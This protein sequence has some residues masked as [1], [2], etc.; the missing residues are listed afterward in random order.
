MLR[1]NAKVTFKESIN[2]DIMFERGQGSPKALRTGE[3]LTLQILLGAMQRWILNWPLN[4]TE[5]PS[6]WFTS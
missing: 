1:K 6:G 4:L 5:R 3:S 2:F